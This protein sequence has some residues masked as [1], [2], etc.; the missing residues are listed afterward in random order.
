MKT[1]K[2]VAVELQFVFFLNSFFADT[3]RTSGEVP[4]DGKPV[5][6]FRLGRSSSCSSRGWWGARSQRIWNLWLNSGQLK[7]TEATWVAN[8]FQKGPDF[9]WTFCIYLDPTLS[10]LV[11]SLV[12]PIFW[13]IK[14]RRPMEGD[15]HK[16]IEVGFPEAVVRIVSYWWLKINGFSVIRVIW[17]QDIHAKWEIDPHPEK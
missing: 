15:D 10:F 4:G 6:M 7:L 1:N 12:C 14:P 9:R 13:R 11:G 3:P 16:E 2:L 8:S 5:E 17:L